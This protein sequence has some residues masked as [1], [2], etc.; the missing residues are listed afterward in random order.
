LTIFIENGQKLSPILRFKGLS[1]NFKITLIM[2]ENYIFFTVTIVASIL[3]FIFFVTSVLINQEKTLYSNILG[4]W[5]LSW[6]FILLSNSLLVTDFYILFPYLY[7]IGSGVGFLVGPLSYLYV[8]SILKQS[9]RLSFSDGLFF[10]P[11]ILAQINRLPYDLLDVHQKELI[12]REVLKN[13]ELFLREKEGLLPDFRLS[14]FRF[15]YTVS[16]AFAQCRLLYKCYLKFNQTSQ[17]AIYKLNLPIF[18]W[19]TAYTGIPSFYLFLITCVVFYNNYFSAFTNGFFILNYLN[20]SGLI[21]FYI[22]SFINPKI[23]YEMVGWFQVDYPSVNLQDVNELS[24]SGF[25][26]FDRLSPRNAEQILQKIKIHFDQ[27]Q[28]YLTLGYSLN[29]LSR[30]IK[31]PSYLISTLINQEFGL[32][33]REYINNFRIS[34]LERMIQEDPKFDLLTIEAIGQKLGFKSR[35]SLVDA[36]KA[37]TGLTPK[38][39]IQQRR[40]NA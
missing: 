13:R 28:S 24:V 29:D 6:S 19:L 37:R 36:I 20:A 33:F 5:T 35:T 22:Y 31:V 15:Y 21:V 25:E 26:R 9:F 34:E 27:N 11:F 38:E 3:G 12:V 16:F 7:I 2:M 32:S 40:L 10:I 30:E 14:E 17:A 39:F 1:S 18:H 8:R 23:L 4:F